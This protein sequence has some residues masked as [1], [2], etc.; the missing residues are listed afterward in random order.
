MT[1]VLQRPPQPAVIVIT[2]PDPPAEPPTCPSC[3]RRPVKPGIHICADC[4]RTKSGSNRERYWANVA[5]GVCTS[6]SQ[7]PP[8]AGKRQCRECLHLNAQRQAKIIARRTARKLCRFCG[9]APAEPNHVGCRDCQL[10]VNQVVRSRRELRLRQGLCAQCGLAPHKPGFHCCTDCLAHNAQRS[11]QTPKAAPGMC[12]TCKQKP[13]DAE[14]G[15][16][17]C[18]SCR[19]AA[20]AYADNLRQERVNDNLCTRCGERPPQPNTNTCID[21]SQKSRDKRSDLYNDSIRNNVCTRCNSRPAQDGFKRC[22][23]CREKA[24]QWATRKREERNP[25]QAPA[26]ATRNSAFTELPNYPTSPPAKASVP[27]IVQNQ[28]N[29]PHPSAPT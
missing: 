23:N 4:R 19:N 27:A 3:K 18:A 8:V 16:T 28:P 25:D 5:N 26:E 13:A 9:Q 15:Y 6:C 7:A 10:H 20:R 1:T 29:S 21:C 22:A 12:N 2:A 14:L 11:R 17:T 24:T